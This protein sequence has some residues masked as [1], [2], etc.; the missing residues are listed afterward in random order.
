MV[1]LNTKPFQNETVTA[2]TEFGYGGR[3]GCGHPCSPARGPWVKTPSLPHL[4]R[5]DSDGSA[6]CKPRTSDRERE[7][8]GPI[9][10]NPATPT[11]K[12][13]NAVLLHSLSVAHAI[14]TGVGICENCG[15]TRSECT[16]C[17]SNVCF[18]F[19]Q[20][21][22]FLSSVRYMPMEC[23]DD[24]GWWMGI[25]WG[26][27]F[28]GSFYGTLTIFAWRYWIKQ[29]KTSLMFDGTLIDVRTGYIPERKP[30][31]ILRYQLRLTWRNWV[32]PWLFQGTTTLSA[33]GNWRKP[34]KPQSGH[35]S[36]TFKP[37]RTSGLDRLDSTFF[38]IGPF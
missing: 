5:I 30:W 36:S 2:D 20:L 24:Y 10:G 34:R 37:W 35:A 12:I 16:A 1:Y 21:R 33:W 31:S 29:R 22:H 13:S 14:L 28:R 6:L 17:K 18:F 27:S 7:T 38:Y 4:N 9:F 15:L 25:Y 23:D 26:E 3:G 8:T 11:L 32:K 19:I